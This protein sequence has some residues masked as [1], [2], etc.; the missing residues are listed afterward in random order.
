MRLAWYAG[1]S[2]ALAAG[3]AVSAFQQRA[4]FYSAMVYLAQ[5]NLCLLVSRSGAP[6]LWAQ[7][8]QWAHSSRDR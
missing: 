8:R 4:N 1:V 6:C 2:T 5:S 7:G 3:V